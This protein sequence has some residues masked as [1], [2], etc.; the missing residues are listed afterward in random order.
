M[1]STTVQSYN[2][3]VYQG[4]NVNLRFCLTDSDGNPTNLEGYAVKG[5]VK[6][7]YSDASGILD[8][9][10]V[11]VSGY[12]PGEYCGYVPDPVVSGYID[13]SIASSKTAALPVG[14]MV[15][16]IE[17]RPLNNV[18]AVAKV[19]KGY[20]NVLPEVTDE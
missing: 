19:I 8:L 20:F 3:T 12:C 16:D 11:I 5:I 15:Y 14:E 9:N 13:V 18:E 10:P 2:F 4:S 1:A 7:R 17:K 6:H